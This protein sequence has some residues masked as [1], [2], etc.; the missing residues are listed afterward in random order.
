M[1]EAATARSLP[2]LATVRRS[3]PCIAADGTAKHCVVGLL[4]GVMGC[5]DAACALCRST[6]ARTRRDGFNRERRD[7]VALIGAGQGA[8]RQLPER[9]QLSAALTGP[10]AHRVPLR[11]ACIASRDVARADERDWR[12][13]AKAARTDATGGA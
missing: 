13:A 9:L 10:N 5:P 3:A 12:G 2:R 4:L 8:A 11:A 1:R 7:A 6:V